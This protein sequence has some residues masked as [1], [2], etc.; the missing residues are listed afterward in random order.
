M[1]KG[2]EWFSEIYPKYQLKEKLKKQMQIYKTF[3][4]T[5]NINEQ[6]SSWE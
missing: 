6:L 1:T 2:K 4:N 3:F 5:I